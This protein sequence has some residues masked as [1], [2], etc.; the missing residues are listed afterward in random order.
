MEP[1]CQTPTV[2]R[3]HPDRIVRGSCPEPQSVQLDPVPYLIPEKQGQEQAPRQQMAWTGGA[4]SSL[5][6]DVIVKQVESPLAG[7][8]TSANG[9]LMKAIQQVTG[10]KHGVR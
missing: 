3:V 9:S 2:A 5:S 8:V 7:R 1:T 10:G 6:V 4:D